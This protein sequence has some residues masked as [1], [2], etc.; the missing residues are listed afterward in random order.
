LTNASAGENCLPSAWR[1]ALMEPT[2][3]GGHLTTHEAI[4]RL[5]AAGVDPSGAR[6]VI[7]HL[8]TGRLA[9]E[10]AEAFLS[11]A[12]MSGQQYATNLSWVFENAGG[13]DAPTDG[14]DAALE[15]TIIW[16]FDQ[17]RE[18]AGLA[19][20]L[21]VLG[22]TPIPN[23][24][25][26]DI[27]SAGE[28]QLLSDLRLITLLDT[29]IFATRPLKAAI[30]ALV[31][32]DSRRDAWLRAASALANQIL[33]GAD[34]Q[35][36]PHV[37]A[38]LEHVEIDREQAELSQY[39]AAWAAR[40]LI[41][42]DASEEA[43]DIARARLLAAQEQELGDKLVV[44]ALTQLCLVETQLDRTSDAER[45]AQEAE[46]ICQTALT[47]AVA[48]D[49]ETSVG[50]I[51][52]TLRLGEAQMRRGALSDALKSLKDAIAK[53]EVTGAD[54]RLLVEVRF[55]LAQ[56]QRFAGD[57]EGARS[58]FE[59]SLEALRHAAIA[60]DDP[61][62]LSIEQ[63]LQNTPPRELVQIYRSEHGFEVRSH[64]WPPGERRPTGWAWVRV[65]IPDRR[66]LRHLRSFR[67][68]DD[69]EQNRRTALPTGESIAARAVWVVEA[70][71]PYY[72]GSLD[73]HLRHLGMRQAT[74]MFGN[75]SLLSTSGMVRGFAGRIVKP[76]T[77]WRVEGEPFPVERPLPEHVNQVIVTV[78]PVSG[79][80]SMVACLFLLDHRV[81]DELGALLDLPRQTIVDFSAQYCYLSAS[82]QKRR[83]VL[84][85]REGI[86][87]ACS[88]WVASHLP[89]FFAANAAERGF[90]VTEV[91]STEIGRPYGH[92]YEPGSSTLTMT[93][94][95]PEPTA[96][97][98]EDPRPAQQSD[99]S[100]YLSLDAFI[101]TV[102]E[103]IDHDDAAYLAVA[104]LG[105]QRA[106]WIGD[107]RLGVSIGG[108]SRLADAARGPSLVLAGRWRDMFPDVTNR[109]AQEVMLAAR[110]GC[111]PALVLCAVRGLLGAYKRQLVALAE[112]TARS[113][114]EDP[115]DAVKAIAN[116]R[117]GFLGL[118]LDAEVVA[119]DLEAIAAT[120]DF[121]PIASGWT[122]AD[123]IIMGPELT[124][125]AWLRAEL[126]AGA[127]QVEATQQRTREAILNSATLVSGA[128][129]LRLQTKIGVLTYVLIA[130]GIVAIV[131]TIAIK[132]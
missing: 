66:R 57:S 25:M 21:S 75:D 76:K 14:Y 91:I 53:A 37:L 93:L 11:T 71:P 36:L 105:R 59:D 17:H 129:N 22:D 99:A 60:D 131:V 46:T 74:D 65:R 4:Q 45:H 84:A 80:L 55:V 52:A 98:V 29:H 51:K 121:G 112:R 38:M 110:V 124:L 113:S 119:R 32:D 111:E 1:R 9:L 101:L 128:V 47:A 127:A 31:T 35:L 107:N 56:V 26:T 6:E 19:L 7:T 61:L 102:P 90:P 82:E 2:S 73:R 92:R 64:V 42:Q 3:S 109:E 85:F 58:Q 125:D 132:A 118:C 49:G 30:L 28:L 96:K 41:E 83:A 95:P 69:P 116:V 54:V 23:D 106:T 67:K 16:L 33:G 70:Y 15:S 123:D 50:A 48:A 89:G 39:L 130:L 40:Q 13:D 94:C 122:Y 27:D 44:S 20:I 86:R 115:R 43:L 114:L 117:E 100:E 120:T 8:G 18:A 108:L 12:G 81:T 79:A 88:A 24:L 77:T 87:A 10:V 63:E 5:V 72:V 126:R 34:N 104:G 68:R 103:A 62:V 78:Y 97:R